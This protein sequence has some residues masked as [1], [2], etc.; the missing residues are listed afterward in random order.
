[1]FER[2]SSEAQQLQ[3]SL[4]GD[5]QAFGHLVTEYQ[6]LVCAITYSATR[7]AAQSEE[8]AQDV[9]LKAWK[10]LAQL[11]DLKKFRPWLCRIA[12]T[13]VQN[14]YRSLGR[15]AAGRS[16]PLEAASGVSTPE[17][18]PAEKTIRREH[19]AMVD[20]ALG[21]LP[22]SQREALV[23]FYREEQS[24]SEVA[25]QLEISDTAARQ[26]ISRARQALRAKMLSVIEE[27][28]TETRPSKAFAGLVVA[29]IGGLAAKST[30]V[31]AA[32]AT[33]VGMSG[34]AAKL[35]MLAAGV[36]IVAGG[37]ALSKRFHSPSTLEPS[38][39]TEQMLAIAS[40]PIDGPSISA[41]PAP[42]LATVQSVA[43]VDVIEI[44]EKDTKDSPR[45][46]TSP[47]V[48]VPE[49]IF[50][51]QAK[52]LLSGLV[53][54]QGTGDPIEGALIQ[55]S[56]RRIFKTRTDS[57]GFY[58]FKKIHEAGNFKIRIDVP[59][60]LG[61]PWSSN[62]PSVHLNSTQQAVKHF[63]LRRACQIALTVVDV[64]GVGI[65]DALVIATSLA[66]EK[67]E[68]VAYFGRT[69]ETDPNG[70]LLY[71]GFAPAETDYL[72]TVLHN[73]S[74]RR[75]I[76][77]ESH[78][79][80]RF[81]Y[82]PAKAL[83]RLTD[84]NRITP[85]TVV[86]HRGEPVHGFVEYADGIP[87]TDIEILAR[88][89][90]WHCNH[91]CY[92]Y[93]VNPDGTFVL[94]HTTPGEYDI[95]VYYPQLE[96]GGGG[97]TG[98][99]FR[100]TLPLGSDE[101]LMVTLPERSPESLASISGGL[102]VHGS[103]IPRS[104]HISAFDPVTRKRG[105][106]WIFESRGQLPETFVIERLEPGT[107]T[108]TFSGGNIEEKV[109][110]QVE[111]PSSDLLVELV[112][113]KKPV[114]AGQVTAYGTGQPISTF[115]V[116][117][118]KLRSLRGSNYAQQDQ[119]V[120]FRDEHGAFSLEVVGPGLYA[121]QVSAKGYAPVWSES[122]STDAPVPVQI[123]LSPGG[124]IS[125]T[126]TNA[127]GQALSGAEVIPLS[128]ARG[129]KYGQHAKFMTKRGS[130]KTQD[131]HFTLENLPAGTGTIKVVH[132]DYAF[133]IVNQINIIE[134]QTTAVDVVLTGG[135][136]VE[137][138]VY[139]DEGEPAVQEVIHFFPAHH[140]NHD[141]SG[142]VASVT[143]D[144][145]GY[146]C[147]TQLPLQLL[148]VRRGERYDTDLGVH[149]QSVT[150]EN[151]SI[152]KLD[153]GGFP[154]VTGRL[155]SDG[156]PL[157]HNKLT[158]GSPG[159]GSY[160]PFECTTQT[161]G[162]G[163]FVIRGIIPGEHTLA[164]QDP[165][166]GLPLK[167]A[168]IE[169]GTEDLDIGL[170]NA[171]V[172]QLLVTLKRP[173]AFW[174]VERL[175]LTRELNGSVSPVS[176]GTGPADIGEPW[177]LKNVSHG[178]YFLNVLHD[179]GQQWKTPIDLE[180]SR[181]H[182]KRTV[183]LP[184]AN[185]SISGQVL[186]ESPS[187]RLGLVKSDESLWVTIQPDGTGQYHLKNLPAGDYTVATTLGMIFDLP[188][189]AEISLREG[190]HL[191]FKTI[192]LTQ[193]PPDR[194]ARVNIMFLDQDNIPQG[195]IRIDL[196]GPMGSTSKYYEFN[197]TYSITSCP[198]PHVLHAEV[199]GFQPVNQAIDLKPTD[200]TSQGPQSILIHLKKDH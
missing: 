107:Y 140:S 56:R 144:A 33:A 153:F 115:S 12:R 134:G 183:T 171:E 129:V 40:T 45:L 98:K 158:V 136:T 65:E 57:N 149:W 187:Q 127:L 132:P 67:G 104:V 17:P 89:A 123:A 166:E 6:S 42:S 180:D 5:A 2:E 93:P 23:L 124:H 164:C 71:G 59:A 156:E 122:I 87:A 96:T 151:G 116:R 112:Y 95:S 176:F 195:I 181:I 1:M 36:A 165:D 38:V 147:A 117:A 160:A 4:Q 82:A 130:V 118:R 10:N 8:L 109:L 190:E 120:D 143:T 16:A 88:P 74:V 175:Y 43:A 30:V 63:R 178:T 21:Q 54:D 131:G 9:F 22:E 119:W 194:V 27:T 167:I 86:L 62:N 7:N 76:D 146:Y 184:I 29:S 114:L 137:G 197:N 157:K 196:E 18:G 75:I 145:N 189:L 200:P 41:P 14:W 198:G 48:P 168:T 191:N 61:I 135:G 150:P 66:G 103:D 108:L 102:L 125:G 19:E 73:K 32:E 70:F 188:A 68:V 24:T 72:I 101:P 50:T 162:Q 163:F 173:E 25:R 111:A 141:Q 177:V 47:A 77:G 46:E 84:P 13:T 3:A 51:F 91:T 26:R 106:A 52:G 44:H 100:A 55:I 28:L 15:D 60:Y 126:V 85:L 174:N 49:E 105:D 182:W 138:I 58:S 37:W 83:V 169:M 99:I 11:E 20:E 148:R 172:S 192:D 142:Q 154:L 110:E 185:A 64:N 53:L 128:L 133:M 31:V 69:R 139:D 34:I 199:P 35:V 90:W 92:A 155:M 159:W 179:G 113:E 81:D 78:S 39:V 97:G 121:L 170:I 79:S 80:T 161:D 186:G 152:D 193:T 94:T